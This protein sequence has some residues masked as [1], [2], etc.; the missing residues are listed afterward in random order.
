MRHSVAVDPYGAPTD[1]TR[2]LTAEGRARARAVAQVLHSSLPAPLTHVF[3]SP[4]VR[5]V[6]TADLVVEG[7]G[8]EG[9]VVTHPP[10]AVEYGTTAQALAC[11]D[12]LP[13]NAVALLV[14]HEPK[15]RVLAGHLLGAST[16]TAFRTASVCAIDRRRDRAD[17]AFWIDPTG[18]TRLNTPPALG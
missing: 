16:M 14:S 6:Q 1:E 10:L 15:V 9:A 17:L 8:Y 2:W 12:D 5:A 18:P 4:L 13:E 3:T 7:N 11:L